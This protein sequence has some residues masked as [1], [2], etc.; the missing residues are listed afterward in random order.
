MLYT[1]GL[2]LR[3]ALSFIVGVVSVLEMLVYNKVELTQ[4]ICLYI[5]ILIISFDIPEV[6]DT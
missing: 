4:V 2:R 5:S 3:L 1:M 6:L